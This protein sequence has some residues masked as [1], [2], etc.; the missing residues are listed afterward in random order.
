M[1]IDKLE[2]QAKDK[3]VELLALLELTPI[4]IWNTD[5]DNFLMEWEVRLS[6]CSYFEWSSTHF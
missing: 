5:L 6:H 3:E 1:Q 4:R 2:K